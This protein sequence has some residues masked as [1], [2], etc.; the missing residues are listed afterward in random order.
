MK[1][2]DVCLDIGANIGAITIALA[3][4]VGATGKVVALEPGPEFFRRLQWN[5]NANPEIS[6]RVYLHNLGAANENTKL[7]WQ[8]STNAPGTATTYAH[9]M[10]PNASTIDVPVVRLDDCG[11]IQKLSRVDFVKIDVDGI[12]L[13]ILKGAA[14]MLARHKP[15]IY[16]ETNMW[17]DELTKTAAEM[18]ALL[19][20]L[21]YSLYRV[22]PRTHALLATKFPDFSFN[23]VAIFGHPDSL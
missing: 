23:T 2:G 3:D 20:Q 18:E 22:E 21:G 11:S 17:N 8:K 1:S 13:D 4:K 14:N 6:A 12:E 15:I 5:I 7:K 16:V 19:L 9:G 10:D